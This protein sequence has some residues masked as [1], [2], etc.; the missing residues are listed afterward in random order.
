MPGSGP[1]QT[2]RTDHSG[3]AHPLRV[4]V[5][6]AKEFFDRLRRM[7]F[8]LNTGRSR[9]DVSH[10]Y[11]KPES[12]TKMSVCQISFEQKLTKLAKFGL[13][14]LTGLSPAE[15]LRYK[16]QARNAGWAQLTFATFVN[17]CSKPNLAFPLR[18]RDSPFSMP[19]PHRSDRVAA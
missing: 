5:H 3:D 2:S 12:D 13:G 19:S 4:R 17:F 8:G 16:A 15:E 11:R 10:T 7:S 9:N 14:L 6:P 1:V 18:C